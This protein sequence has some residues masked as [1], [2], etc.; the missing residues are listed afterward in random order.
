M[1]APRI[2]STF[3]GACAVLCRR[4]RLPI[5]TAITA[6]MLPL[7]AAL[8]TTTLLVRPRQD[9]GLRQVQHERHHQVPWR[10]QHGR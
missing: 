2:K 4:C 5:V 6:C 9:A 3:P 1:L 8:P 10:E 7:A